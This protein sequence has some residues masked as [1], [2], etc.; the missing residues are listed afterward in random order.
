M[1]S[2]LQQFVS[3]RGIPLKAVIRSM[4]DNIRIILTKMFTHV[5]NFGTC[6]A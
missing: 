6:T 2:W 3:V 1:V 4:S 5:H